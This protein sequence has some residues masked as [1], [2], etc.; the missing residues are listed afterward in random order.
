MPVGGIVPDSMQNTYQKLHFAPAVG[1]N[2]PTCVSGVSGRGDTA[3][4][5]FRDAR[6]KVGEV[7]AAP[8]PVSTWIGITGLVI[9]G[10]WA[11]ISVPPCTAH[12]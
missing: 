3:E 12:V 6:T 1:E 10:A 4:S 8:Y 2:G 9:P 5:E 11:E 7:L